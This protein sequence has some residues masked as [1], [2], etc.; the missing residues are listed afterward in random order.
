VPLRYDFGFLAGL[1]FIE[2]MTFASAPCSDERW[3]ACE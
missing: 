2:Q 1:R 3:R